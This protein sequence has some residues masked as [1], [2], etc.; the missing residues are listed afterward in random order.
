MTNPPIS[1]RDAL[2]ALADALDTRRVLPDD[3]EASKYAADYA[4]LARC[5]AQAYPTEDIAVR[6]TLDVDQQLRI[7]AAYTAATRLTGTFTQKSISG[8]ILEV[9]ENLLPWLRD[10]S[11]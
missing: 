3:E 9:A 2:L 4:A 8:S 1:G 6:A 5:A 10:G 7:A 11:R